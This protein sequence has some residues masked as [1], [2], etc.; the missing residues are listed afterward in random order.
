M[1]K[2]QKEKIPPRC[3][4]GLFLDQCAYCESNFKLGVAHL[5]SLFASPPTLEILSQ[6]VKESAA[7]IKKTGG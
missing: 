7:K 2:S 1:T 3:M 6:L 5:M 4:H